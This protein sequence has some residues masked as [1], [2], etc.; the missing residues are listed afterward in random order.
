VVGVVWVLSA[1]LVLGCAGRYG[2]ALATVAA[3][4]A[5]AALRR[6]RAAG[7]GALLAAACA[8]VGAGAALRHDADLRCVA[9][10]AARAR[11]QP[12]ALVGCVDDFPRTSP[13]GVSFGFA[14]ALD[15]RPVRLLVRAAFFDVAY[16]DRYVLTARLSAPPDSAR[17]FFD[18]RGLSGIARVR[19]RDTRRVG[20]DAGSWLMREALWPLHRSARTRVSR[21]LG[22]RAALANGILLG[23]RSQLDAR[24]RAA[25]RR[26]GITHL[27]AIS[28]M[29]LTMIAACAAALARLVPRWAGCL[30]LATISLY[31]GVVGSVDSLTRAYVMS[32]L[33]VGARGL[34]RPLRPLD[35]LGKAVWL[36]L[37]VSPLSSRSIGLQL[38]VAATFAVLHVLPELARRRAG[39]AM[40]RGARALALARGTIVGAFVL[41]VAAEAFVAPLQLSHFG[42]VSAVGPVATVIF[43]VPVSAVLL[44]ALGA[45]LFADVQGIGEPTVRALELASEWTCAGAVRLA[46]VVPDLIALPSPRPLLYYGGV[47]LAWAGRGRR[48]VWPWGAA[49][50][51]ASLVFAGR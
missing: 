14:T 49:A 46:R 7:C 32:V 25:I 13:Y 34:V 17:A 48:W 37:L 43:L 11:G 45:A 35:A 30:I 41:S 22:D 10:A 24:T 6:D 9:A 38:S 40:S 21:A 12:I 1:C 39:P 26:L 31:A 50:V 27:I 15:G 2:P 36:M 42:G 19:L 8:A 28:G 33:L 44:G 23:E 47:A 51:I 29:H 5:W 3:L 18:A 20:G 16:G 4:A